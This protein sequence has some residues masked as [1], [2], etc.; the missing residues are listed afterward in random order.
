MK[1]G[2][3]GD[4]QQLEKDIDELRGRMESWYALRLSDAAV[5]ADREPHDKLAQ[6]TEAMLKRISDSTRLVKSAVVP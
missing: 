2:Y 6:E 5:E 4:M 1:T 3:V